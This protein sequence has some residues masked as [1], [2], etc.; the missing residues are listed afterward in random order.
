[1][2]RILHHSVSLVVPIIPDEIVQ[3]TLLHLKDNKGKTFISIN[4]LEYVRIIINY[5]VAITALV[6]S[7]ITNDSHPVVLGVTDNVSAKTWTMVTCKKSI[8][9]QALARVFCGLLIGSNVGINSKWISIAAN[10]IADN[11]SRIKNLTLQLLLLSITISP[12]FN[13]TMQS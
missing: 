1:M 11:I 8:I 4:C 6:D 10:K 9:G 13:R 7:D 12:N 3:R 2:Q 5:C